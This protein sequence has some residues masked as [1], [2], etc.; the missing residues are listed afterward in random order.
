MLTTKIR[1]GACLLLVSEPGVQC[2]VREMKQTFENRPPHKRA[3]RIVNGF[4]IDSVGAFPWIAM[5][6]VKV[7][8]IMLGHVIRSYMIWNNL[9]L[10]CGSIKEMDEELVDSAAVG[11]FTCPLNY[12]L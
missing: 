3:K 12:F 6:E 10:F 11:T 1:F 2:G 5:I 9:T 7:S 8:G 4:S